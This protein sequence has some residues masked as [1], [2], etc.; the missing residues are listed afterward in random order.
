MRILLLTHGFNSLAQRVFAELR[1]DGHAV[2]VEY[3]IADSVTEEAVA[4]WQPELLIAPYLKRRIPRS[5]WPRVPCLVVHPGPPGD[6]G[7]AALDWAILDGAREWGV[8]VL[9]ATD[10]YDAGPLWATQKFAMRPGTKSSLYRREVTAAAVRA[11]RAAIARGAP[12]PQQDA[13][14]ATGP[15]RAAP[16][17]AFRSLNWSRMD[18]PT[19]L[20]LAAAADGHP[21]ARDVLFGEPVRVFDL[22]AA[23]GDALA[24]A[25]SGSPGD[26]VGRR[27][28][29]L[30]RRTVDGAVWIGQVR[31]DMVAPSR[32]A[33]KLAATHAFAQS[34][35]DLFEMDVPLMRENTEWDELRYEEFGPE[36]AR[37]GWFEFE[38]HNGA[39]DERQ[40]GRLRDALRSLRARPVQVLVLAG[41]AEFFSNGI[42]LHHIEAAADIPGDGVAEASWR[43]IQAIDDA[44]LEILTLT[45]RLTIAALRGN[46]GAG[47]CFVALAADEVWAHGGVIL[48]PHYKNMGN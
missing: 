27:G 43:A 35:R 31:R 29:A 38:F 4:L 44:V 10:D 5:V 40:S 22:H 3:D 15:L 23:S 7:P 11:L 39:F 6:R 41:G 36:G 17:A 32:P 37:V 12:L 19:L 14:L 45:D 34:A 47:G 21:G 26:I 24:C 2:S 30:L 33:L 28:P 42:H 13:M 1:A 9:Q 18:T 16:A 25:E 20:R 8:T 46:A 48:N